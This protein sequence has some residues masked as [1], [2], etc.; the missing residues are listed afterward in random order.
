MKDNDEKF[1]KE[2]MWSE[3]W[4]PWKKKG[5]L[6]RKERMTFTENLAIL[7]SISALV[8]SAWATI[9]TFRQ[10][11]LM[12]VQ[13]IAADSNAANIE[14]ASAVYDGCEM[15]MD[16][17]SKAFNYG[18]YRD[19]TTK[20]IY[21]VPVIKGKATD[22]TADE[23]EAFG[24]DVEKAK[25]RISRVFV[26]RGMFGPD[27]KSHTTTAIVASVM[28]HLNA[29]QALVGDF[30]IPRL[31][32]QMVFDLGKA[33]RDDSLAIMTEGLSLEPL[34]HSSKRMPPISGRP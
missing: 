3:V 2:I 15:I 11:D 25:K 30:T 4:F 6:I 27:Q 33:C 19:P 21:T 18:F 28:A 8:V 1:L 23:R 12:K 29:A 10:V 16:G 34:Q 17:P 9:G 20:R 13:L 32:L 14:M 5:I 31:D 7:I 24:M 22:L 26:K